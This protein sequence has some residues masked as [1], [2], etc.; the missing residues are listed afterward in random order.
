MVASED[1][2]QLAQRYAQLAIASAAPSVAGT[3][4]ALASYYLAQSHAL[5]RPSTAQQHQCHLQ[6]DACVGFGD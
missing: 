5:D 4:M 3:L 6:I 1:Y 2:R